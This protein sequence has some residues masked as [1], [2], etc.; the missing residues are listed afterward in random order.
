MLRVSDDPAGAERDIGM[1]TIEVGAKFEVEVTRD[2]F[3]P[4]LKLVSVGVVVIEADQKSVANGIERPIRV[5][6]ATVYIAVPKG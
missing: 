1:R 2:A 4:V 5:E 6:N 3:Q